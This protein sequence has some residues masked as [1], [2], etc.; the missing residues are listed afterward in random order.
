MYNKYRIK[1]LFIVILYILCCFP[2]FGTAQNVTFAEGDI[3][4][5]ATYYVGNFNIQ[6]GASDVQIF[7]YR[8]ASDE[9]YDV[10]VF[11]YL[12][13]KVSMIS[14]ALGINE[15]QI[16]VHLKT[17]E[18]QL[19]GD[20]W[21]DNRDLSISATTLYD[22][23]IPPNSVNIS[24]QIIEKINPGEFEQLLS[25]ILTTGRL[26][27]GEY[28]FE[29]TI[30]SGRDSARNET[31]K[32]SKT[33]IVRTPSALNL[34]SPGSSSLVDSSSNEIYTNY[35]V[36][37]WSQ[38]CT[39]CDYYIRVAE[40]KPW[41]HSSLDEAIEDE[42]TFPF[43]QSEGWGLVESGVSTFQY[44]VAGVSSLEMGKLYAWQVKETRP[45]T[46]GFEDLISEINLFKIAV[47]GGEQE[48][49]GR[50]SDSSPLLQFLIQALGQSQYETLFGS[51]G[52]LEGFDPSG[53]F[54]LNG[55]PV[56]ETVAMDIVN[57]IINGT[58]INIDVQ[59]EN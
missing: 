6:T 9:G 46:S 15:E 47:I 19:R 49:L 22:N 14:P 7:R 37:N 1:N 27:D 30:Y 12:W 11:V 56:D 3:F 10:P 35:P 34:E 28:T 53:R 55:E 38:G 51:N 41:I 24:A 45:T 16:L 29:V 43:N 31:D 58:I 54:T 32:I 13:F 18:F 40:Y 44:P 23:D 52:D 36:F 39:G 26:A 42:T 50:E 4:E 17:N 21:I 59:V 8:L 48:S 20:L 2:R 25:A 33:F 57:Q 5:Y